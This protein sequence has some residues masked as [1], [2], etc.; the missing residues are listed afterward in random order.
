[1]IQNPTTRILAKEFRRFWPLLLTGVALD[2]VDVLMPFGRIN[3]GYVGYLG[4]SDIVTFVRWFVVAFVAVAMAQDDSPSD[5]RGSWLAR[6]ISA[7][8]VLGAKC[9]VLA[10]GLALPAGLAAAGAAVALHTSPADSLAS[11]LGM[12]AHVCFVGTAFLVLGAITG[13]LLQAALVTVFAF[14]LES[15]IAGNLRELASL[16]KPA[17]QDIGQFPSSPSERTMA[18]VS[19]ISIS[20]GVS[21][22][23]LHQ[24]Y[25]RRTK[26]T[27][28][29]A[30]LVIPSVWLTTTVWRWDFVPSH[31]HWDPIPNSPSL[32]IT[33]TDRQA[34][35]GSV[36]HRPFPGRDKM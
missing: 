10:I 14:A 8:A 26:R 17:G 36:T 11:A 27:L 25:T 18:I 4:I 33:G 31:R 3:L 22:L 16:L 35:L 5:D 6:P 20:I 32:E 12:A 34:F 23:L 7:G 2:L 9:C 29:L 30:A 28:L 15:L 1:M 13:S 21:T 19:L 24:Y